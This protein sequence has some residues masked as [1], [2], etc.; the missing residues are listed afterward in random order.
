MVL[1]IIVARVAAGVVFVVVAASHQVESWKLNRYRH[2]AQHV[3]QHK[4]QDQRQQCRRERHACDSRCNQNRCRVH[5]A[6]CECRIAEK[7]PKVDQT[8]VPKWLRF[9]VI[10]LSWAHRLNDE[11]P[12]ET[13]E[14]VS[15]YC[16]SDRYK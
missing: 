6:R 12:Q 5:V 2:R 14:H 16:G 11:Q 4:P 15:S 3:H 8:F 13:Y 9:E 1:I 10:G 7:G